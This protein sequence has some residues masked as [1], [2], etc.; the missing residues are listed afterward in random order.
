M[1]KPEKE[2]NERVWKGQAEY[3]H[4]HLAARARKAQLVKGLGGYQ[5]EGAE[6]S[7]EWPVK[8]FAAFIRAALGQG[9]QSWP[10]RLQA[11]GSQPSFS[12]SGAAPWSQ[13]LTLPVQPP[14]QSP[15][16][17]STF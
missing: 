16:Q 9:V 2:G 10:T 7:W 14:C 3:I 6:Q 11:M 17:W 12:I 15:S 13:P 1:E 8:A 4:T 5:E